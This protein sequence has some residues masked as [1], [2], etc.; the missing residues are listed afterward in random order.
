VDTS[1]IIFF[2][3]A[4]HHF[5]EDS[6]SFTSLHFLVINHPFLRFRILYIPSWRELKVKFTRGMIQILSY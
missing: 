5:G 1:E 3:F 4:G 2:V 6:Q